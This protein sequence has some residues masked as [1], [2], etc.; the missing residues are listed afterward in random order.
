MSLSKMV[1]ANILNNQRIKNLYFETGWSIEALRQLKFACNDFNEAK[2]VYKYRQL[3]VPSDLLT[4]NF[5]PIPKL[6]FYF[7]RLLCIKR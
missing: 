7:S 6:G 2:E 3:E 4:K 1:I 5:F